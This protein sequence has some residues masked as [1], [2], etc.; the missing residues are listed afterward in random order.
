MKLEKASGD[1]GRAGRASAFAEAVGS[2]LMCLLPSCA[3]VHVPHAMRA[4]STVNDSG[5][6]RQREARR[7]TDQIAV[8]VEDRD[9]RKAMS[10]VFMG[11][12]ASG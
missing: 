2:V 5:R 8:A 11:T 1:S 4:G 3:S 10:V 12:S 6:Q 7:L 9:A